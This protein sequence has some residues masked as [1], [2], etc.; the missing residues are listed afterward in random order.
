M[1]LRK[2]KG[3]ALTSILTGLLLAGA[4]WGLSALAFGAAEKPDG[5]SIYMDKCAMC[6]G[7]NGR[8]F[9]FLH[10]PDFTDPKWQ[11]SVKDAQLLEAIKHGVKGTSM[12]AWEG[13]LTERQMLAVLKRVRDFN[14]K[15]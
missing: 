13:K 8:G 9:S 12:P 15:R 2:H 1:K 5:D 6:H 4:L 11:A 7:E 3:A 10:T 14:R